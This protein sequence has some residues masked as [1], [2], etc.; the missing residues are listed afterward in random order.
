MK[1]LKNGGANKLFCAGIITPSVI[2][3]MLFIIT[4]TWQLCFSSNGAAVAP[5]GNS[6]VD[7]AAILSI[8]KFVACMGFINWVEKILIFEVK[9]LY[10][11]EG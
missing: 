4:Q 2:T 6:T 7:K 5:D 10:D 11:I 9:K 1:I 3:M 8:M